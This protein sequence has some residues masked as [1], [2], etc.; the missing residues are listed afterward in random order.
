MM[1]VRVLVIDSLPP[2]REMVKK[3]LEEA[4]FSTVSAADAI[5]GL[6]SLHRERPDLVVLESALPLTG[7]G[8]VLG[9]IRKNER[10]RRIPVILLTDDAEQESTAGLGGD[11]LE[12][13]LPASVGPET[14]VAAARKMVAASDLACA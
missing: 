4:G 9:S 10:T 8:R 7:A 14:V 1:P 2:R 13:H 5:G 6:L 3:A 11:G 12:F